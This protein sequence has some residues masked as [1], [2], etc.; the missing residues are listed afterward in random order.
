MTDK[1]SVPAYTKISHDDGKT[2]KR[3]LEMGPIGGFTF[4]NGDKALIYQCG[5]DDCKVLTKFNTGFNKHR[6]KVHNLENMSFGW[7]DGDPDWQ[8]LDVKEEMI[9]A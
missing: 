6:N 8:E 4:K 9:V 1:K 2:W 7:A 5:V 3:Q